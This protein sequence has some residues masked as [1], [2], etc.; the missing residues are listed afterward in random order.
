[1]AQNK[2]IHSEYILPKAIK[3]LRYFFAYIGLFENAEIFPGKNF[4]KILLFKEMG[5]PMW[6]REIFVLGI[7]CF[8][9]CGR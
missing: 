5:T 9:F 2:I 7:E 4:L 8:Y 6:K 3:S 1:M